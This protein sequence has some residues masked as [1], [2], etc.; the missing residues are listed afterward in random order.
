MLGP[1]KDVGNGQ[2][3]NILVTRVRTSLRSRGRFT[4]R[5]VLRP[6]EETARSRQDAGATQAGNS[7]S[8]TPIKRRLGFGMTALGE[9]DSEGPEMTANRYFASLT[10]AAQRMKP[11]PLHV[12]VTVPA[13]VAFTDFPIARIPVK[14][15]AT[16]RQAG[17]ALGVSEVAFMQV[18]FLASVISV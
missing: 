6:Y 4:G 9:G 2:Y 16:I 18:M 11:W 17:F 14:P 12:S 10:R 15:G 13:P 7:R 8:L 3:E 5:S 1:A